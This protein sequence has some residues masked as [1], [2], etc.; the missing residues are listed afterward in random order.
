MMRDTKGVCNYSRS[1][2]KKGP[3]RRHA[4]EHAWN[5]EDRRAHG[6]RGVKVRHGLGGIRGRSVWVLSG[7][8]LRR[9]AAEK[10]L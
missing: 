1:Y 2:T 10:K 9:R 5:E 6:G 3:G 4:F 8:K 7:L